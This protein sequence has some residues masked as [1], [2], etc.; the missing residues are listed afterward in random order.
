VTVG[1]TV[2]VGVGEGVGPAAAQK[3]SIE[4]SGVRPSTS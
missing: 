2:G 1:V 3:I 4:A